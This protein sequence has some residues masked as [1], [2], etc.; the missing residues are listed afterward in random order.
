MKLFLLYP[1]KKEKSVKIGKLTMNMN[2]KVEKHVA[3][4]P[5]FRQASKMKLLNGID[6]WNKHV[7]KTKSAA[8]ISSLVSRI[9]W[10]YFQM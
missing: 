8:V 4:K 6:V 9:F 10:G 5:Y 1:P 2:T 7:I 3:L